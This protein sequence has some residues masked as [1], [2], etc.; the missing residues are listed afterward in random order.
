MVQSQVPVE[1]SADTGFHLLPS[2]STRVHS[3]TTHHRIVLPRSPTLTSTSPLSEVPG[4]RVTGRIKPSRTATSKTSVDDSGSGLS[5][6][7]TD[8]DL[9]EGQEE[10]LFPIQ[11]SV[12]LGV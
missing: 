3:G 5:D 12:G 10:T 7:L 11:T 4:P 9:T 8:R 1:T 6:V 2:E